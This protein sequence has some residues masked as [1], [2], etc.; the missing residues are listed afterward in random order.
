[1]STDERADR[2]DAALM[3]AYYPGDADPSRWNRDQD[4]APDD[5]TE[6][7]LS[8]VDGYDGQYECLS[9][10]EYRTDIET[11]RTRTESFCEQCDG[12][13]TFKRTDKLGDQDE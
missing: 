8:P 13:T 10:R 1:M 12:F 11:P 2:I 6:S 7:A 3:A 5:D 4:G 9:C